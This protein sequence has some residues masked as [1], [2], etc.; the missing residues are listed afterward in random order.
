MNKLGMYG[1]LMAALLTLASC[2]GSGGGS[3][4]TGGTHYT[5]EQLAQ[6]FVRRVNSD[7]YGYDLQLVK[8]TTLK[9]DYIVVYDHYYRTYDAYYIGA[10]N[11]GENLSYYLNSYSSYFYYGLRPEGSVYVDPYTLTRFEKQVVSSKNLAKIQAIKEQLTVSSLAD[12]LKVEYGLSAEKS[13]DI[14]SFAYKIENSPAGTFKAQ[15]YDS[16]VKELTGSSITEFKGDILSGNSSSLEARIQQATKMTG[17]G[18]EGVNKLI[19][20]LFTAK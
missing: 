14:A 9:Y 8:S 7:V 3:T 19:S 15:D 16:F 18:S 4:S 5:H 13:L 20:D 6:E 1:F 11:V 17:M 10:Y 12:K 2:G